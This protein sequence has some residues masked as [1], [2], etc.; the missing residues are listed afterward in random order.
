MYDRK[1]KGKEL[2]FEASGALLD[3]S[4]VMRDRQTDSW[5]SIMSSDAIGGQLEGTELDVL[6]AGE[7]VQWKEWVARHPDTLVLSVGGREHVRNNP[8]DNYFTSDGT[9]RGLEVKDSRLPPKAPIYAFTLGGE[10]YAA[11][12]SAFA[13][14]GLFELEAVPERQVVLFREPGA[15]IFASSEAWTVDSE[16]ASGKSPDELLAAAREDAAGFERLDGFDTFWYTW[17]AVNADSRLLR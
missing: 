4:L 8:Y 2:E 14:G 12:H 11:P 17:V 13:G 10:T 7:K 5:W 9:F 16:T 1:V 3:A 15:A 6:P